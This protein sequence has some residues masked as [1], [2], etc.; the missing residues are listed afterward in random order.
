[1]STTTEILLD[2][3]P[4]ILEAFNVT[5]SPTAT[6]ERLKSTVPAIST[7]SLASFR[8]VAP[9]II[10]TAQR[11]NRVS[12][13][14]IHEI[15]NLK[16]QV[17]LLA[18]ERNSLK[19]QLDELHNNRQPVIQEIDN[20]KEQITLLTQERNSLKEQL[21][22]LHNNRQPVIQNNVQPPKTFE[23]WTVH[24]DEKGYTRLHK[25]V[26]G[27]VRGVYIG[28]Q[29]DAAKALERIK[30]AGLSIIV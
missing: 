21:D 13:P 19:E 7:I 5:G 30:A 26:N 16:K 17:A 24:T 4:A 10:E 22:E 23:G 29:W 14:V 8:A 12:E 27:K 6:Y 25:K 9:V 18:Q 3:L 28:R 2:H 15:D 20:L 11:L 1:M